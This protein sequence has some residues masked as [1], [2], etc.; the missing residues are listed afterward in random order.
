MTASQESIA[1][2]QLAMRDRQELADCC[3]SLR[4]HFHQFNGCLLYTG[5]SVCASKVHWPTIPVNTGK[6]RSMVCDSLQPPHGLLER[7]QI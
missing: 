7:L 1:D 2:V 6:R 5:R 3:Q 4:P